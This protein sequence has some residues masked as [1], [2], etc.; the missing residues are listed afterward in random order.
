MTAKLKS[1]NKQTTTK[2]K[3]RKTF[4]MCPAYKMCWGNGGSELV[5]V[6]NQ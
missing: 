3:T 1:K 6:A 5:E 4:T 2:K